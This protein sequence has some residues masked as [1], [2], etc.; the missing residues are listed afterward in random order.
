MQDWDWLP[1]KTIASI[2]TDES[3][4]P[5]TC[6]MHAHLVGFS[7][8]MTPNLVLPWWMCCYRPNGVEASR[9]VE[10]HALRQWYWCDVESF[11]TCS[12]LLDLVTSEMPADRNMAWG[13]WSPQA[14]PGSILLLKPE[15]AD[16]STRQQE[17]ETIPF[18]VSCN[19]VFEIIA[20]VEKSVGCTRWSTSCIP[21]II[22]RAAKIGCQKSV[23]S[24]LRG[25]AVEEETH[26]PEKY[27]L[28]PQNNDF[29]N[30]G[31]IFQTISE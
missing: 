19:I 10:S 25:E 28:P 30:G 5:D 23:W 24:P 13:F 18:L 29:K 22:I 14:K 7:K 21:S 15:H 16:W 11:R 31:V 17:Q 20:K 1:L 4:R 3:F 6:N 9:H 26:G 2:R 12:C 8:P 27:A